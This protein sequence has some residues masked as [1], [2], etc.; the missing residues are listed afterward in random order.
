[1][2]NQGDQNLYTMNLDGTGQ[3]AVTHGVGEQT[4]PNWVKIRRT[5]Q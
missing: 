3:R 1:V 5:T 4:T 2:D